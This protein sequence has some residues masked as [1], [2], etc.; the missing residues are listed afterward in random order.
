MSCYSFNP[1]EEFLGRE[2]LLRYIAY[3]ATRDTIRCG[4]PEIVVDSIDAI[5]LHRDRLSLDSICGNRTDVSAV[6]TGPKDY[7]YESVFIKFP[8]DITPLGVGLVVTEH[9]VDV[10]LAWRQGRSPAPVFFGKAPT[11]CGT[12]GFE[13]G[14]LDFGLTTAVALAQVMVYPM[15]PRPS[16]AKVCDHHQSAKSL[17]SQVNSFHRLPVR[18]GQ[19]HEESPCA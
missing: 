2:R 13:I 1:R 10:G 16:G 4:V 15:L 8:V 12:S 6:A 11:A 14:A 17:S 5:M 9:S 18:L 7:G 3:V 19:K